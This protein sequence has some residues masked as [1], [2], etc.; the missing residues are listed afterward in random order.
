MIYEPTTGLA[1]V[2]RQE[3]VLARLDPQGLG[4]EKPARSTMTDSEWQELT[5]LSEQQDAALDSAKNRTARAD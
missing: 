2:L 4:P 5:Q 3:V 1:E